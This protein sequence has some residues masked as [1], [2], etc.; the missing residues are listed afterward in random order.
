MHGAQFRFS[1]NN[2]LEQRQR[3]GTE[4]SRSKRG[5]AEPSREHLRAPGCDSGASRTFHPM[6]GLELE[7]AHTAPHFPPS[8]ACPERPCP[9]HP[10][11]HLAPSR[12]YVTTT[13]VG[14][15]H[16]TQR[17]RQ[18]APSV[19]RVRDLPGFVVLLLTSDLCQGRGR[20]LHFP[21]ACGVA[22]AP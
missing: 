19:P 7:S 12:P 4:R 17:M 2:R 9:S 13:P 10:G 3:A 5:A 6:E 15:L 21:W 1:S 20:G 8:L 22:H 14:P 16:C 11:R 18:P